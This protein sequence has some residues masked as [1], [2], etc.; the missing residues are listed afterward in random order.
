MWTS[1]SYSS[2]YGEAFA[3]T[4]TLTNCTVSGNSATGNGGGLYNVQ[5]SLV[6]GSSA[7]STLTLTNCTVSGNTA[8]SGGAIL[9]QSTLNVASSVINNNQAKGSAGAVG[10]G[11]GILSNGG[12]VAA[13]SNSGG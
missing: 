3:G 8:V 11:G 10:I 4:T 5:N 6:E 13:G 9:N 1:G 12:S 2:R 7:G